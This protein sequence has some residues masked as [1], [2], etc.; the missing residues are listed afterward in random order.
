MNPLYTSMRKAWF[1]IVG[2]SAGLSSACVLAESAPAPSKV[3]QSTAAAALPG[4]NPAVKPAT[5]SAA[6]IPNV[7]EVTGKL[8]SR[9]SD[10]K[11]IRLT[12]DGGFN[13]EFTYDAKTALANGGNPIQVDDLSYGDELI[14]RYSGKEL[15]AIEIDRVKKV[16][17]PL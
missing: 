2:L 9:S 17:R 3:E 11:S 15:Y 7:N 4:M 10:P 8:Q 12:I 14:V 1:A 5:A 13:M 16:P 6:K